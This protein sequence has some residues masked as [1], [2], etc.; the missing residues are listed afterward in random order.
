[1]PTIDW[2]DLILLEDWADALRQIL[3][4][5]ESAVQTPLGKRQE[6]AELLR[7]FIKKSPVD[8]GVLDNIATGAIIDLDINIM[9]EALRAIRAREATLKL[10]ISLITGVTAQ[11]KNDAKKLRLDNVNKVLANAKVALKAL[12]AANRALDPPDEELSQKIEAI[13]TAMH[14]L[15]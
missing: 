8:A 14:D 5:A 10:Q 9:E 4:A 7:L 13:I 6:V 11:A 12:Q 3:A 2:S 15:G 1:M